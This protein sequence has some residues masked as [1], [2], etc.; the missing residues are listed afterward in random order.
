AEE[1]VRRKLGEFVYS[2]NGEGLEAVAGGLLLSTGKT[3][4][5]AESCTGGLLSQRLTSIPGSS[6]YFLEGVVAYGNRAKVRRLGVPQRSIDGNGAV[7]PPVAEAMARGVRARSGADLGLAVTGI[8][9]PGGGS[10][11]KPVGLVFT[12]LAWKGGVSVERNLFRGTREIV[13]S[14]A[15]QKALDM[16]RRRLLLELGEGT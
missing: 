15:A 10:E 3:V 6:A 12:A 7:S 16:L 1:L 9:G 2:R 14:Q 5:C 4:A 11:D 8:A 13:R